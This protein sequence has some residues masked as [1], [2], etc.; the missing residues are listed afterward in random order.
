MFMGQLAYCVNR[1]S[2]HITNLVYDTCRGDITNGYQ[3]NAYVLGSNVVRVKNTLVPRGRGIVRT[4]R[5]A[6][7]RI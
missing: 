7:P 1:V 5:D 2:Y 3:D 6:E 4:F